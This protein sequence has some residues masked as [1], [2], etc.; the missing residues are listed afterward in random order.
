MGI[1]LAP[2]TLIEFEDGAVVNDAILRSTKA[3]DDAMG[4]LTA[5]ANSAETFMDEM[6]RL[7]LNPQL[8]NITLEGARELVAAGVITDDWLN[9]W[10]YTLAQAYNSGDPE[11]IAEVTNIVNAA[12]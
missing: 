1:Q 3:V 10:V 6:I 5:M 11:V 12:I 7:N 9:S 8:G 4:K 2:E